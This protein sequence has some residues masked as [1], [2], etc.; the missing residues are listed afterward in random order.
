MQRLL[1]ARDIADHLKPGYKAWGQY[2]QPREGDATAST[3]YVGS[4]EEFLQGYEKTPNK[5]FYEYVINNGPPVR[6][7]VALNKEAD[8]DRVVREVR[9]LLGSLCS[10]IV[11]ESAT[12]KRVVFDIA[13]ENV[14]VVRKL[15]ETAQ[16]QGVQGMDLSVYGQRR[17]LVA[18]S[19]E[20]QATDVFV[21]VDKTIEFKQV[22]QR[23]LIYVPAMAVTA[24]EPGRKK[25]KI[26]QVGQVTS[27]ANDKVANWLKRRGYLPMTAPSCMIDGEIVCKV[28]AVK[29]IKAKDLHDCELKVNMETKLARWECQVCEG[30]IWGWATVKL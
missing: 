17:V 19:H 24:W 21:P 29:C 8:V 18:Y 9:S 23:S 5:V 12:S 26:C 15:A 7:H 13:L 14:K 3:Y 16:R 27:A 4:I 28:P 2:K 22:V 30:V 20:W 11:L 6:V 1:K 25:A 10:Y